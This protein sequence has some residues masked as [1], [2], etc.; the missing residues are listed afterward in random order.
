[1]DKLIAS[2]ML[3]CAQKIGLNL[4]ST[5]RVTFDQ[6]TLLTGCPEKLVRLIIRELMRRHMLEVSLNGLVIDE[7]NL[8][9][10]ECLNKVFVHEPDCLRDFEFRLVVAATERRQEAYWPQVHSHAGT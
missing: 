7:L 4:S 9:L 6:L 1:M 8:A 2:L 3:R 5:Q 10:I